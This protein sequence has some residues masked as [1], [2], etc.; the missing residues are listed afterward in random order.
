MLGFGSHQDT[1]EVNCDTENITKV[2]R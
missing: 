2:R 1:K